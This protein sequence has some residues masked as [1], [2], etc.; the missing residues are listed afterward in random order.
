MCWAEK[1][2]ATLCFALFV[3]LFFFA[4]ISGGKASSFGYALEIWA[5]LSGKFL[6]PL[7]LIMRVIDLAIGG[8]TRRK[9]V[10]VYHPR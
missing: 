8:P 5:I 1:I 10:I 6:L 7:W 9:G 3:I 4:A 2:A